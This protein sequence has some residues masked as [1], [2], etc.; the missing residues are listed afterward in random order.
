MTLVLGQ[1]CLMLYDFNQRTIQRDL[2]RTTDDNSLTE[3]IFT[4]PAVINNGELFE[5]TMTTNLSCRMMKITFEGIGRGKI[6]RL[7]GDTV[8]FPNLVGSRAL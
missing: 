3:N 4:E 1:T 6:A 8:V 7:C 2:H 5:S